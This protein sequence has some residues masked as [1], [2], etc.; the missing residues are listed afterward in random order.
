MDNIPYK[1]FIEYLDNLK[2]SSTYEELAE[3]LGVNQYY[4][5][6]MLNTKGYTPPL[7]IRRKLG[8]ILKP[9]TTRAIVYPGTPT[10]KIIRDLKRV[11][12]KTFILDNKDNMPIIQKGS[13]K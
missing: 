4:L 6:H 2:R 5:W 8:I 1:Q 11:T 3:K 12:G 10:A 13:T 7:S 9:P